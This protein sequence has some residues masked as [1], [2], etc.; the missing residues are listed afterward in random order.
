MRSILFFI[1][2]ILLSTVICFT[3]CKKDSTITNAV[4]PS[5]P[6]SNLSDSIQIQSDDEVVINNEADAVAN[7]MDAALE[8]SEGSY[9]SRPTTASPA[10]P[11]PCDATVAFDTANISKSI[12]VTYNGSSCNNNNYT[13]NG[14]V[15]I[16]FDSSLHWKNSAAQVSVNFDSLLITRTSDSKTWLINGTETV[17][18]VSGGLIKDL[19]SGDSI[20]HIVTGALTITPSDDTAKRNITVYVSKKNVFTYNNGI[21]IISTGF[22][23]SRVGTQSGDI[24]ESG[25]NRYGG[26]FA[27]AITQPRVIEQSCGFRLVSG[28]TVYNASS[29]GLSSYPISTTYI[30]GKDTLG[31]ILFLPNPSAIKVIDTTTFGLDVNGN[32]ITSCPSGNFYYKEVWQRDS[33]THDYIGSY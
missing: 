5:S 11:Y 30:V 22:G 15:I 18:N 27:S 2:A 21:V 24:S 17:F 25:I 13:R 26:Y 16:S 14:K 4:N 23:T 6:S 8:G 32:S 29:P 1:F 3:A 33:V 28:Q 10:I 7:D 9:A 20:V 19:S 31:F 12:T